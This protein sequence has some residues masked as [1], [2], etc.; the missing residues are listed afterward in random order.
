MKF[1]FKLF[2]WLILS[3]V[4]AYKRAIPPKLHH[5]DWGNWLTNPAIAKALPKGIA[6]FKEVHDTRVKADLA[7]A[8]SKKGVPTKPVSFAKR[9]KLRKQA[10]VP[11]AEL[12]IEWKKVV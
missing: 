5:P 9:E 7:H 1:W 12:I 11:W 8:K 6:W 2:P 4:A 10:T 3:P